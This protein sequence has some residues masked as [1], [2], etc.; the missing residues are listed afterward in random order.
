MGSNTKRVKTRRALRKA[1]AGTRRKNKE[2]A[3]GSTQLGLS[4]DQPNANE[5]AQAKKS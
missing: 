2:R 4:L 1:K 5:K 3:T